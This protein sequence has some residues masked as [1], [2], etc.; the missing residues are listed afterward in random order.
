MLIPL[1][2]PDVGASSEELRL[3]TWLVNL[4]EEIIEGDRIVE[5]IIPG[6]TFDISSPVSGR[7]VRQERHP[8]SIVKPGDRLGWIEPF[9]EDPG[10][11]REE[12][13]R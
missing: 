10:S 1:L 13:N 3:C 2:V 4:G 7:V 5:L 9:A 6:M 8:E 11:S 12:P